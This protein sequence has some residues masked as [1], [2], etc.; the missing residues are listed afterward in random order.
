MHPVDDPNVDIRR[1]VYRTWLVDSRR[2]DRYDPRD[3]DVCVATYPKSG[4]T[5]ILRIVSLLILNDTRPVALDTLFPWWDYRV[6]P[7]LD[8]VVERFR[9]VSHQRCTKTHLPFDGLP[10]F[11]NL[12]YIHCVRDPR[13]VALSYHNHTN[14]FTPSAIEEMNKIGS[15]DETILTSYPHIERDPADF[16]HTW[17]TQGALHDQA[18]GKPFLSYFE[19]E[20]TYFAERHRKN[21]LFVHYNDLKQDLTGEMKR[22]AQF[23]GVSRSEAELE[24]LAAAA[25]FQAMKRDGAALIPNVIKNFDG[26]AGRLFNKGDTARWKP[27]FRA[28]DLELLEQKMRT[29]FDEKYCNW[30]L[31]GRRAEIDPK[32]L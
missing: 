14:G 17:L 20:K 7:K 30:I 24:A 22:I 9:G 3:G 16:F 23:I 5:W 4:T 8:D 15:D 25:D 19:F 28:D 6:G 11:D 18:D 21:L 26:G 32:M 1:R 29:S 12:K 27:I 31:H 2:W 13:D 10:I